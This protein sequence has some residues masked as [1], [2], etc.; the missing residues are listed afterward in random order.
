LLVYFEGVSNALYSYL[1]Q[2]PAEALSQP[3]AGWSKPPYLSTYEW[4][5]NFLLD[6]REHLGEI[7]AIK[8]MWERKVKRGEGEDE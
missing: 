7:K 6:S 3:P 5:R 4:L 1:Q 8:A 2:M